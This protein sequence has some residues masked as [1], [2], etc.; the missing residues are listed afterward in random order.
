MLFTILDNEPL[1]Q[2]AKE[3]EA[4]GRVIQK[5]TYSFLKTDDAYVHTLFDLLDTKSTAQK[6]DYFSLPEPIGAHITITYNEENIILD[7]DD[8]DKMHAFFVTKVAH[9]ILGNKEYVVLMI[10]A[11]SLAQLRAKYGLSEKPR[12]KGYAIDFHITIATRPL[13]SLQ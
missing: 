3:L 11:P 1:L 7:H 8:I 6:P 12:Y 5:E 10:S 2:R 13:L 9:V 4:S